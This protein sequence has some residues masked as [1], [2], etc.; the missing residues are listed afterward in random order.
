MDFSFPRR[1]AF[2][3]ALVAGIVCCLWVRLCGAETGVVTSVHDG[4]TVRIDKDLR[5]RVRFIDAPELG[6]EGGI[7]ARDALRLLV[8]DRQVSYTVSDTD[9]YGR[10]VVSLKVKGLDVEAELLKQGW[11]WVYR[12]YCKDTVC[13][14]YRKLEDN[15]RLKKAG[16]WSNPYPTAPWEWRKTRRNKQ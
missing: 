14:E 4:D 2:Y 16:L 10:K 1:L 11:A 7:E 12:D 15:A 9:R 3:L 8:L 13:K 6:Q 5:C